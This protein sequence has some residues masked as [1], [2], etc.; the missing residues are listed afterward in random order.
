[1][2]SRITVKMKNFSSKKDELRKMNS[3]VTD[4]VSLLSETNSDIKDFGLLLK[5]GWEY[6]KSLSSNVSNSDIDLIYNNAL[7]EG[8]IGGKILGA[9]GG[10]GGS[11]FGW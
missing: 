3:M 4:A 8:A 7:N 2:Q 9:G 10:G 11:G 6:K 1:M 5:E